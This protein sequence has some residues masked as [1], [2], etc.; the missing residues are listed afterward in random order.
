MNLLNI[1]ECLTKTAELTPTADSSSWDHL[2]SS[3]WDIVVPS[4][5]V[6]DCMMTKPPLP[7][8]FLVQKC[9]DLQSKENFQKILNYFV[10]KQSFFWH[11]P[12]AALLLWTAKWRGVIHL[13]STTT[14]RTRFAPGIDFFTGGNSAASRGYSEWLN[15][16]LTQW[17]K[18]DLF[19]SNTKK[20]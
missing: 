2:R 11:Q 15:R 7:H 9:L 17:K 1:N 5:V 16:F 12:N 13:V 10:I 8:C 4:G 14:V 18:T 20:R 3:L 6:G 19:L